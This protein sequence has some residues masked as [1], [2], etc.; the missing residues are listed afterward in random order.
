MNVYKSERQ[1]WYNEVYRNSPWWDELN[2]ECADFYCYRCCHCGKHGEVMHH[3][4]YND[5]HE[6]VGEDVIY[7]CHSCHHKVHHPL[8]SY[9]CE[10]GQPSEFEIVYAGGPRASFCAD[11]A[12]IE[13]GQD[14]WNFYHKDL[15]NQ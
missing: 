8:T 5:Y 9:F 2:A 14:M 10:C 6:I 7:L 11:C 12:A 1:K 13:C 3:V 4:R 15:R